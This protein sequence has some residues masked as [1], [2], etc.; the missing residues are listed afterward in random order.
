[1]N[2]ETT[3]HPKLHH[4]GLTT[5]N[6]EPLLDWYRK[7]LGMTIVHQTDSAAGSRENTPKIKARS[8][9]CQ[10]WACNARNN[11]IVVPQRT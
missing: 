3:I 5:G 11:S 9:T 6:I 2:T 1:M 8:T 4:L 10:S 7:L